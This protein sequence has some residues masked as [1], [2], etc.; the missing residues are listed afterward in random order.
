LNNIFVQFEVI[1][2]SINPG[3]IALQRILREPNSSA[4]DFVNPITPAFEAA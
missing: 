2:V 1:S 3:A 4:T